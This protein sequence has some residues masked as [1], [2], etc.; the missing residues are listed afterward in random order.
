MH[1]SCINLDLRG[2][3]FPKTSNVI[4]FELPIHQSGFLCH[5]YILNKFTYRRWTLKVHNSVHFISFQSVDF[6]Q[7]SLL[8]KILSL[9]LLQKSCRV[10]VVGEIW[11]TLNKTGNK[12]IFQIF[13]QTVKKSSNP[14]EKETLMQNNAS[15]AN[16]K[17]SKP[18]FPIK[19]ST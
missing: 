9:Q 6:Y 17:M 12:N 14:C 4:M 13:T 18:Q 2:W 10:K 5:H 3:A 1:W 16:Y 19:F 7:F 15:K 8:Q 11:P